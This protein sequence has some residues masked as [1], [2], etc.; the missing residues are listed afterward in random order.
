MPQSTKI[1]FIIIVSLLTIISVRLYIALHDPAK[2]TLKKDVGQSVVFEGRIA[3]EP[4]IKDFIQTFTLETPDGIS[5]KVG[6]D[7]YGT[8]EYGERVK[9]SGKLSEPRNFG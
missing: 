6:A 3:T 2:E 9:V 1:N 4:Q 7:K 5:I 8:Y